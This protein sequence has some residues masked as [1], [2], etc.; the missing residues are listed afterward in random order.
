M[1]CSL[2]VAMFVVRWTKLGREP[3]EIISAL[4][5]SR[6][7]PIHHSNA[8]PQHFL[9]HRTPPPP[10]PPPLLLPPPYPRALTYH[11]FP[12]RRDAHRHPLLPPRNPHAP[13][14]IHHT[15]RNPTQIP[16]PH[17]LLPHHTLSLTTHFHP[18][19]PP[20]PHASLPPPLHPTLLPHHLPNSGGRDGLHKH[21]PHHNLH[22]PAAAQDASQRTVDAATDATGGWD[23]L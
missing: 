16:P 17:R 19:N 5:R 11:P 12:R 21:L 18:T 8:S 1:S 15:L 6:A 22:F 20:T 2:L 23:M 4:R 14:P 7:P 13:P 10:R 9:H 3:S